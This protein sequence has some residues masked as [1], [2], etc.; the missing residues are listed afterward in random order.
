MPGE[1]PMK[2]D[3]ISI[4]PAICLGQPAIRGM[5]ITVSIILRLL[6]AGR[7]PQEILEAYPELDVEDV[8]QSIQFAAWV[9][10]EQTRLAPGA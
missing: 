2:L 3:R 9:V 10:S 1:M 7:S 5:R 6:G 8:R 4:N